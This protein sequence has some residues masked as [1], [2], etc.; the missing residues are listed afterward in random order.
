MNYMKIYI[1][2][3]RTAQQR[4]KP[5][6]Y[7]EKH[8]VFPTSIFG[9]NDS[10][11]FLTAK[12]HF[13]SH[14]LLWKLCKKRYGI[15]HYKT[16]KMH[17][18]FNQMSWNSKNHQR[19]VSNSFTYARK[20]SSIYNLGENN[21]AKSQSV[22][23]KIKN[24][25]LGR[26]RTDMVGKKSF[27]ASDE[28]IKAGIEKMRAKKIGV[29]VKYPKNRKRTPCSVEKAQA[30][31]NSRQKTKQKYIEM[32]E[33]EF[34]EWLGIQSKT[35]SDGRINGNVSRAIKWRNDASSSS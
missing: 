11:V 12:E 9:R 3:I 10:T 15:N 22:R 1:R 35:R 18:A 19:Y 13:I 4:T 8:H 29:K 34:Q 23:E 21:P 32:T 25:K 20:A 27:G 5:I 2:M 16:K 6:E 17:F 26:I 33:T 30:I 7:C 14:F 24:S 31:S 28:V